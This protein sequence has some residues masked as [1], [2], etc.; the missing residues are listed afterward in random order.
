M[1]RVSGGDQI[2]AALNKVMFDMDKA[3]DE[4]VFATAHKVRG[5]AIRSIQKRSP[6]EEQVRYRNG[7]K[8]TVIASKPGDAPNTDT[9]EI[10]RSVAVEHKKGSKLAEVG[11][12]LVKGVWLELGTKTKTG[13]KKMAARP[14]LVPAKDAEI[15]HYPNQLEAALDRQIEKAAR[16]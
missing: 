4:A 10:V 3:I 12:N 14:W 15:K 11:T 6:G 2:I 9:G 1:S 13:S 16:R 5:N 7:K 8:R